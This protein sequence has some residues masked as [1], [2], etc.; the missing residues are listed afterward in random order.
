M[1]S[2]VYSMG[3]EGRSHSSA[4]GLVQQMVTVFE[5]AGFADLIRPGAPILIMDLFRP[6][7]KDE[8]RDIVT[9]YAGD[10]SPILQEDFYNSLLASFRVDEVREQ[11]W[12]ADL[13]LRCE[14][15]SNRHLA[16]WGRLG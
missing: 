13:A 2:Q 5:A 10:E 1:G 11:L 3:V 15:V 4:T 12:R 7:S 16:V 8:A 6:P 14:E 9:T